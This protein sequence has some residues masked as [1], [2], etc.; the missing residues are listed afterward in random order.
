MSAPRSPV[1]DLLGA[2]DHL[3]PAVSI[4]RLRVTHP[5]DDDNLWFVR[6]ATRDHDVQF[7][8]H[9]DGQPPFL[10]EGGDGERIEAASV[11]EAVVAIRRLLGIVP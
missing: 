2:L 1:D 4:A 9:P 3:S 10:V 8:C 7:E 11:I 5:A 6:T